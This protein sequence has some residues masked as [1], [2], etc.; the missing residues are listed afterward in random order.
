MR[1]RAVIAFLLALVAVSHAQNR[2]SMLWDVLDYDGDG[3]VTQ[4][5]LAIF[6]KQ[7]QGSPAP[8]RTVQFQIFFTAQAT[9]T[10]EF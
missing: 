1:T 4:T 3:I 10:F 5:D 9:A 2:L 7:F 6:T 8:P